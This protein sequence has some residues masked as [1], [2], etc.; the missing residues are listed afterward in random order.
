[1][2]SACDVGLF[3]DITSRVPSVGLQPAISSLEIEIYL[4]VVGKMLCCIHL[5]DDS[6]CIRNILSAPGG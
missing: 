2:E 3:L 4:N 1:M 6:L 5:V